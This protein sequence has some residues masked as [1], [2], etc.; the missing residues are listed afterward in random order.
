[1]LSKVIKFRT[2][3]LNY[4]NNWGQGIKFTR[5]ARRE[6]F[7]GGH[8]TKKI[9]KPQPQLQQKGREKITSTKGNE[10]TKIPLAKSLARG[11]NHSK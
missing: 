4:L 3:I 11:Q 2:L 5:R 6:A 7:A 9:K 1:M 10:E 8:R